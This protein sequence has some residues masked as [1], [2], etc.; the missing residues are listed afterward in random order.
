LRQVSRDLSLLLSPI[1][2]L[3][4]DRAKE[5]VSGCRSLSKAKIV[6][7]GAGYSIFPEKA[8]SFLGADMG[9]QGEGEVAFPA[10]IERIEQ[11]NALSG[12]CGLFLRGKGLQCKR[13]Y[14]KNLDTLPL[15]D[16]GRLYLL[17][18]KTSGCQF[19]P[20]EDAP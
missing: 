19:R 5:I 14:A 10:L 8:L 4:Q 16:T 9:I 17:K 11:G 12:V 20:D 15:P 18:R 1:S 2:F 13:Q 3:D 6:L 7:G